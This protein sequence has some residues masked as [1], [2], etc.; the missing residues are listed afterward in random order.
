MNF[1]IIYSCYIAC[2]QRMR[3]IMT[4]DK[5]EQNSQSTDNVCVDSLVLNMSNTMAQ[6]AGINTVEN[7]LKKQVIKSAEKEATKI[8]MQNTGE[9]ASKK[10]QKA[11]AKKTSKMVSRGTYKAVL[12][13]VPFVSAVAGCVF[14]TQRALKG[15]WGGAALELASG[16]SG[17]FPGIGTA[18]STGVDACLIA[19][20]V[21]NDVQ[22][23][24]N[25]TKTSEEQPVQKNNSTNHK[26]VAELLQ[27]KRGVITPPSYKKAPAKTPQKQNN[28]SPIMLAQANTHTK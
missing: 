1:A 24:K 3:Y 25:E 12:K 4:V 13:K 8:V 26:D 21:Y 18:V 5:D 7:K 28:V 6:D 16:V 10:A 27:Q 14:A 22:E 17:C 23:A 20:D 9:I 11:I 19:K 2:I 15:D